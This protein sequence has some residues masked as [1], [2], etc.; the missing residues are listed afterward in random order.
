VPRDFVLLERTL[1]LL[2][3]VCTQLDPDMNP[4][5]V[6]Q[7][8]LQEFVLGNRDWAQIALDAA[9]DMAL[10]AVTIPDDLS[11]YLRRANRGEAEVK[12]RGLSQAA[13]LVY[14]GV[15]QLIYAAIAIAAGMAAMRLY[16][17]GHARFAEYCLIGAGTSVVLLLGSMLLTRFRD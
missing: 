12:V 9:K 10:K 8:Y 5:E 1:L 14:S 6:V 15:H 4:M 17:S 13:R 11:K 7:P 3:G 16:L 2:A